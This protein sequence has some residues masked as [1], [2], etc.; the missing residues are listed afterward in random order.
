MMRL[1]MSYVF[2]LYAAFDPSI[3]CDTDD[4]EFSFTMSETEGQFATA[5]IERRQSGLSLAGIDA[6]APR[7][8]LVSWSPTGQPADA[9]LI[10]RAR[11]KG[12]PDDL[13][14]P[15]QK[16]DLVCAPL[17]IDDVLLAWC[18]DN[19]MLGPET[20]F[21]FS[22]ADPKE[23]DSY[24]L[25]RSGTLRVDPVT[26][27]ISLV[28]DLLG[29]TTHDLADVLLA[30]G[31]DAW[32]MPIGMYDAPA[33]KYTAKLTVDWTQS[34][35]GTCDIG[36]QIGR[37]ES[38]D[39]GFAGRIGDSLSTS[40]AEGWST[41]GGSSVKTRRTETTSMSGSYDVVVGA[42]RE[43][44]AFGSEDS[45]SYTTYK[46]FRGEML[47][48]TTERTSIYGSYVKHIVNVQS[49]SLSYNY[50][51]PRRETAFI[52]LSVPCLPTILVR[53]QDPDVLSLTLNSIFVSDVIRE[54]QEDEDYQ[55]GDHVRYDER[56]YECVADHHSTEYFDQLNPAGVTTKRVYADAFVH[57][58]DSTT[59]YWIRYRPQGL[60][61]P[62]ATYR[63]LDTARGQRCIEHVL[64]RLRKTG[65]RNLRNRHIVGS[66]RWEDVAHVD[67]K[68]SISVII[69]YDGVSEGRRIS[70]KVVTIER[71]WSGTG[72]P[73]IRIEAGISFGTGSTVDVAAP[74]DYAEP[75][76]AEPEYASSPGA[77]I[78][79]IA[80]QTA[81]DPAR[82]PLE[83]WKLWSGSYSCVSVDVVNDANEQESH[84]A[85]LPDPAQA[86]VL[87]PTYI[88]LRMRS[89]AASALLSRDIDVAAD[90]LVSP[91]GI[92]R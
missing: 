28:D 82:L 63:F 21:L 62:D 56:Y 49:F 10:A 84:M 34:A 43:L 51:Q 45:G 2:D 86:S 59:T 17:D 53:E 67:L 36:A 78:A 70:A 4:D 22:D 15:T 7:N 38:L 58:D 50:S 40:G 83:A 89:L 27:E 35:Q 32:T 85:L 52:D 80:Y 90:L 54:W 26:H 24:L 91:L 6:A 19:L 87:Y 81:S 88:D 9:V 30:T 68:D 39:E 23:V 29:E 55:E 72:A 12:L 66:F 75:D 48:T 37:I 46:P 60:L 16:I 57:Y 33:E 42:E 18:E 11:I 92:I 41:S 5:Q 1:Y 14:A 3:H 44:I 13:L 74:A 64:C 77:A 31:G 20:D 73:L 79:E 71:E 76:Y 69:L 25:G 8:V 65:R 47:E 61:T